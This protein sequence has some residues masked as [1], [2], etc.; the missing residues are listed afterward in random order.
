MPISLD[1]PTLMVD[2]ANGYSPGIQH[3]AAFVGTP[4]QNG[5]PANAR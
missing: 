2:T 4:A 1:V 3:I 5:S